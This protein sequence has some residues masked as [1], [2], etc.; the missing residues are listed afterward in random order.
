MKDEL[1]KLDSELVELQTGIHPGSVLVLQPL[2]WSDCASA[3]VQCVL[4]AEQETGDFE[5]GESA[6]EPYVGVQYVEFL[7]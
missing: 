4:V 7:G 6:V 3:E 1:E 5:N 2:Q